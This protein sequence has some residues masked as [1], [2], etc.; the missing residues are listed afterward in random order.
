MCFA[1]CLHV[2]EGTAEVALGQSADSGL[3]WQRVC[4]REESAQLSASRYFEFSVRLAAEADFLDMALLALFYFWQPQTKLIL[5]VLPP[6][7]GA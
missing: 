1:S 4:P 7:Q 2:G 3:C 5:D 6:C